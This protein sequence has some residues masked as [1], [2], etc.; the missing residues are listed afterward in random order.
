MFEA[1]EQSGQLSLLLSCAARMCDESLEESL[2]IFEGLLQPVML[3]FMGLL[4]GFVVLATMSPMIQ[5]AQT[6]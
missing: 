4:A 1:G 3:G 6:L 5:L 2:V